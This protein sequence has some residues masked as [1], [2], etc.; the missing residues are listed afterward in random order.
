MSRFLGP[1][2]GIQPSTRPPAEATYDHGHPSAY[3]PWSGFSPH[4]IQSCYPMPAWV[5]SR[6]RDYPQAPVGDALRDPLPIPF[7]DA[8]VRTAL[9]D[10]WKAASQ[11]HVRRC[12]SVSADSVNI[13][14]QVLP[15]LVRLNG[16][17][18]DF[19]GRAHDP[20]VATSGRNRGTGVNLQ[21]LIFGL[22]GKPLPS[23]YGCAAMPPP[24][25]KLY[26]LR[27]VQTTFVP[28]ETNQS[29]QSTDGR[30]FL[31][32]PVGLQPGR[33]RL[34]VEFEVNDVTARTKPSGFP[35]Y[36]LVRAFGAH[37]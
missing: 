33:L 12:A 16:G 2:G 19:T 6:I 26:N 37:E 21:C 27:D 28:L 7:G 8:E 15:I 20:L 10:V 1:G 5:Y 22:P 31:N 18:I 34:G 25:A 36:K 17:W 13:A 3:S 24:P 30:Q 23:V 4:D 29:G 11:R 14:L 32:P 35:L 9:F